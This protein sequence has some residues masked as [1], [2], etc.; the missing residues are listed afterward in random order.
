[1][2]R[3]RTPRIA[4]RLGILLTL[5]A[6]A[7]LRGQSLA[8]IDLG[9]GVSAYGINAAGQV[10]GCAP[11]SG[12]AQHAFLYSAGSM[13]DLGTLGGATSCGYAI[14]AGGQV[15]GYADTGSASHA[16]LYSGGPL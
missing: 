14:N 10:T 6:A 8:L 4:A 12:G 16:F 1:M 5:A 9:S 7:P 2:A 15:T 3:D 13:T 11:A